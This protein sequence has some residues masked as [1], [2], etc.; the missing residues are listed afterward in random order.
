M[1][2]HRAYPA[3]ADLPEAPDLAII[4]VPADATVTAVEEC[5]SVGARVA[6]VMSAGFAEAGV[7]G[8]HREAAMLTA[9]RG[10]SMRVVGPNSQGLVNF[11]TGTVATFSTMFLEVEPLDGP[12]AIASQSGIM[13]A[14]SA[15]WATLTSDRDHRR[16]HGT[17][18]IT[19]EAAQAG[20][21]PGVNSNTSP[22]AALQLCGDL[23]CDWQYGVRQ[24]DPQGQ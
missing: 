12:V 21:T 18:S 6:I 9:A 14:S 4:A 1:Q 17:F 8:Q 3:V 13:S 11:G 24:T 20:A 5:A 15:A 16:C 19:T 7:Q 10:A 23:D 2:G 22:S